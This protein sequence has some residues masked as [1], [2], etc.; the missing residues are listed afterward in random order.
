MTA[1]VPAYPGVLGTL[2]GLAAL[3]QP[4]AVFTG[5]SARSAAPLLRSAGIGVDVLVGGDSV[6]RPKP[7]PDGVLA[8]AERLGVPPHRLAYIGDSPADLGAARA[9]GAMA[10]AA[11]W[12]HLFDPAEPSDLVLDRPEDALQLLGP[13]RP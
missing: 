11:A 12:G 1:V 4:I 6:A 7:A 5:A 3:G 2:A 10:V 9:S 8:I 13:D